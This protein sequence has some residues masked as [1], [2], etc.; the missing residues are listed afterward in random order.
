MEYQHLFNPR[1]ATE[2]ESAFKWYDEQSASAADNLIISVQEA[3]ID[4]CTYPL[5]YRKT[6]KNLREVALKKYPYNII[7]NVDENKKLITIISIYHHKRNPKNK[8]KK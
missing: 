5:R 7:Y 4:I 8:Y 6:Y 1:A 3:I 2:Y